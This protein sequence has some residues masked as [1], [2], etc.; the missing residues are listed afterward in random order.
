MQEAESGHAVTTS[1]LMGSTSLEIHHRFP[2]SSSNSSEVSCTSSVASATESPNL[3]DSLSPTH[4]PASSVRSAFSKFEEE[5]YDPLKPQPLRVKKM[6]SF[7]QGNSP[8]VS[9]AGNDYSSTS[10][11]SPHAPKASQSEREK[12][13]PTP[14]ERYPTTTTTTIT[15]P[16][17]IITTGTTSPVFLSR[18]IPPRSTH[19]TTLR[20][21]LKHHLSTIAELISSIQSTLPPYAAPTNESEYDARRRSKR[22]T[23]T[24]TFDSH[25]APLPNVPEPEPEPDERARKRAAR[26]AQLKRRGVEWKLGRGR[27]DGARYERLCEEALRELQV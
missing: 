12:S 11:S 6:E 10:P 7:H 9:S 5:L 21:Q 14:T 2:F 15:Q 17:N 16:T 8:V 19:L 1:D 22:G 4:S 18:S 23:L 24:T 20:T 25:R 13:L 27:F 26:I 3:Y